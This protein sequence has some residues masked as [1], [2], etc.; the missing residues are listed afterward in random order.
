M[1]RACET[2]GCQFSGMPAYRSGGRPGG[3][4]TRH[5]SILGVA[6]LLIGFEGCSIRESPAD[7]K[8]VRNSDTADN[9]EST[10]S[11]VLEHNFGLLKPE[12]RVEY[13][14][15]IKNAT[16]AR[17]TIRKVINT[18]SCT[19]TDISAQSIE[20]NKEETVTVTYRAGKISH[21]DKR[22]VV[23]CF[24]EPNVPN[25]VL[26]VLA[27]VRESLTCVPAKLELTNLGKG[28]LRQTNFEVH[29]FSDH[30]W[31]SITLTPSASWLTV[32]STPLAVAD[33]AESPR[34]AWRITVTANAEAMSSGSHDAEIGVTSIGGD[35]ISGRLPVYASV[36]S[37]VS[38]IP[39]QLFFGKVAVGESVSRSITLRF[40][41]D[42]MPK[43]HESVV[44][45]HDLGRQLQ[46]AWSRTD[47]D[48]WELTGTLLPDGREQIA[49]RTLTIAFPGQKMPTLEL[50]IYVFMEKP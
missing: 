48:S 25:V 49:G 26:V 43:S 41:P 44:L 30:D 40:A 13:R 3:A 20:P 2:T 9:L 28:Q 29:N 17:W 36:I 42:A 21:D 46:L 18:C 11:Q 47:G 19:A 34:Q 39:E 33:N 38:A 45:K 23:L 4:Y 50:P 1:N 22:S 16:T 24:E 31:E 27:K 32:S 15:I 37:P 6:V 10:A 8:P 7:V 35:K 12:Q 5:L 14:Y